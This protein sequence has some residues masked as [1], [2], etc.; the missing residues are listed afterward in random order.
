MDIK[1]F[2]DAGKIESI[3]RNYDEP[4]N[5][6]VFEREAE[7]YSKISVTMVQRIAKNITYSYACH[8]NVVAIETETCGD[9]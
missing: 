1:A 9:M 7:C 6:L 2:R 3:L 4:Y 8:L 5:P